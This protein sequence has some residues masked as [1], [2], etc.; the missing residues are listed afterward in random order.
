[1]PVYVNKGDVNKGDAVTVRAISGGVT[2]SATMRA[3]E[4]GKFGDSII[5]EHLN[6]AGTTTARVIGPKTLDVIQGAK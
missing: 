3:K 5:V 1:M 4:P 6:G 2:V